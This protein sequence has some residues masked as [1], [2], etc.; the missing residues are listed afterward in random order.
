MYPFSL[1][2]RFLLSET[3]ALKEMRKTLRRD[4]YVMSLSCKPPSTVE[5]NPSG[6]QNPPSFYFNTLL[7]LASTA[8]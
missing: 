7:P 1:L 6:F 2:A 4:W 3:L 8:G 5:Q